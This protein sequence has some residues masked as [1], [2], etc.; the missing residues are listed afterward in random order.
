MTIGKKMGL[1]FGVLLALVVTPAVVAVKDGK[2]AL[3]AALAARETGSPFD[4]ILMDI[5]MP[6]MGGDEATK[7]L[8][9]QGYTGKIISLTAN[10]ADEDQQRYIKMGFDDSA[11]KPFNRVKLIETIHQQWVGAEAIPATANM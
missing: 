5:Q 2:L 8:R 11:W 9:K 7:L 1:G 10:T 6:L 4:I 3:D